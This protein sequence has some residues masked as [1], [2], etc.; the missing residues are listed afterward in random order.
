MPVSKVISGR[1]SG[2][3]DV[4]ADVI[5]TAV[6]LAWEASPT[7]NEASHAGRCADLDM[8]KKAL[9]IRAESTDS[10]GRRPSKE[11]PTK[12]MHRLAG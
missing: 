4:E 9:K 8:K 5:I 12:I 1:E 2:L 10:T 11:N 7:R 6:K 3:N